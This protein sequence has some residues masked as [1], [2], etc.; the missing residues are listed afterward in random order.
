[1][2]QPWLDD[3]VAVYLNLDPRKARELDNN[4]LRVVISAAGG[5]TVQCGDHGEWRDDPR[6]FQFSE[7]GTIRYGVKVNGKLN[8]TSGKSKGYTVAIG[9]AWEL[10]GVDPPFIA[11]ES[12]PLPAIGFALACYSQGKRNPSPAGRTP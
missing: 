9:L 5:A 11:H 6:W 4:C 12:D 1:M 8:D 3:A 7:H 10:L 2:S